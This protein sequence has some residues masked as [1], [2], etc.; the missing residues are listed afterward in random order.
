MSRQLILAGLSATILATSSVAAMAAPCGAA[1]LSKADGKVLVNRGVGFLDGKPGMPLAVGDHL[2]LR[3]GSAEILFVNG[4]GSALTGA[5]S[6]PITACSADASRLTSTAL[7]QF[8]TVQP[9]SP[10]TLS[11][12]VANTTL[13]G[14]ALAP[15]SSSTLVQLGIG[16]A[17]LAIPTAIIAVNQNGD[18]KST[19]VSIVPVSPLACDARI[20]ASA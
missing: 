11:G 20:H 5:K 2:M 3:S 18:Q 13:L 6:M 10:T 7:A 8:G 1:V 15:T 19:L 17:A 4:T 9:T 14:I 16:A 12:S